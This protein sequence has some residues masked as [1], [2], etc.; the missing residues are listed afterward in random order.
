VMR[1]AEGHTVL[2]LYAPV[3]SAPCYLAQATAEIDGQTILTR[4]QQPVPPGPTS[5]GVVYVRV[6]DAPGADVQVTITFQ[7][8]LGSYTTWSRTLEL[9]S[10]EPCALACY[11]L[12]LRFTAR[13]NGFSDDLVACSSAADC[14]TVEPRLSCSDPTIL[15]V[16]CSVPIRADSI[17]AYRA[18]IDLLESSLCSDI[19]PTCMASPSCLPRKVD[20]I[21]NQCAF[22][23]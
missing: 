7:G 12:A 13:R 5:S 21:S 19:Q 17:E 1:D 22:A 4:D 11:D 16:D 3:G 18:R 8:S 9:A 6:P 2:P 20:C 10:P 15:L 23:P 14:T